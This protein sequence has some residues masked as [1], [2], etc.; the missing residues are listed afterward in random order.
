M[1][2][3]L[4]WTFSDLFRSTKTGSKMRTYFASVIFFSLT[5]WRVDCWWFTPLVCFFSFVT[6]LLHFKVNAKWFNSPVSNFTIKML[7]MDFIRVLE[8]E[9]GLFYSESL[10]LLFPVSDVLWG[11]QG[12]ISSDHPKRHWD[13]WACQHRS[14]GN[15][16]FVSPVCWNLS[17]I[18]QFLSSADII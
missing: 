14:S 8:Q 6:K 7:E 12:G 18:Q 11:V 5:K 2:N 10:F 1:F 13:S 3:F 9:P 17:V 15:Q 16:R 4:K